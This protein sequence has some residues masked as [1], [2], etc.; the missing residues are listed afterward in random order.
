MDEIYPLLYRGVETVGGGPV[1]LLF[2]HGCEDAPRSRR[3]HC[4][5]VHSFRL[6]SSHIDLTETGR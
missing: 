4:K 5:A 2:R 6:Y 3:S 1:Q